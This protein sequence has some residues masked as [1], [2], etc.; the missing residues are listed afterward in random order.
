MKRLTKEQACVITAYTRK[1]MCYDFGDFHKY[2]E[3]LL[4][5]SIMTHEF[6]S[7]EIRAELKKKT[8]EDFEL[9]CYKNKKKV[10]IKCF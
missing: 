1:L 6:A 9:L 5:I 8:R 2:V 4:R 10:H 3:E 7:E